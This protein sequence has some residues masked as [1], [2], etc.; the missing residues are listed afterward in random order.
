MSFA[1]L[2]RRSAFAKFDPRTPRIF[3]KQPVPR[4]FNPELNF[5]SVQHPP[6]FGLKADPPATIFGKTVKWASVQNLDGS[7][8]CATVRNEEDRV[9]RRKITEHLLSLNRDPQR[10]TFKL[11][12]RVI[13]ATDGGYIIG[14]G[15]VMALLPQSEIPFSVGFNYSDI[16]AKKAYNFK[17]KSVETV[18][19]SHKRL[20]QNDNVLCENLQYGKASKPDYLSLAAQQGIKV[21]LSLK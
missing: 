14:I 8:G 6:T 4:V 17:L 12:G 16:L 20:H 18:P 5:S 19:I 9:L 2:F 11:P 21:T 10:G 13:A 1:Q 3:E 7:F 15:P